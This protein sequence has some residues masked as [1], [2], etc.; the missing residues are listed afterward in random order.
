VLPYFEG[1][2]EYEEPTYSDWPR[3]QT[4]ERVREI[5]GKTKGDMFL[6]GELSLDDMVTAKGRELT[7]KELA[8]KRTAA[9]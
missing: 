1:K 4:P 2:G 3:K 6:R 8:A 9:P 5:L 7:L